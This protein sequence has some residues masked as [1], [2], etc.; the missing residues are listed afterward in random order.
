[1][2]KT[3]WELDFMIE[4]IDI[5]RPKNRRI[6]FDS[7]PFL[8]FLTKENFPKVFD[9]S[10]KINKNEI[11]ELCY[12]K[13]ISEKVPKRDLYI[14]ICS[15]FIFYYA[16]YDDESSDKIY[17]RIIEYYEDN[18]KKYKIDINS[19]VKN[20]DYEEYNLYCYCIPKSEIDNEYSSYLLF[21]KFKEFI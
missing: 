11:N 20:Y 7:N 1:M 9:V 21:K 10:Q 4:L 13:H 17:V 19:N 16:S 18:N 3:E 8:N 14:N 15:G 12:Y 2:L 5:T 6:I